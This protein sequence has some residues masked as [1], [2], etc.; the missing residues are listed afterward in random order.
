MEDSWVSP[1]SIRYK[2]GS[3]TV[4]HFTLAARN[5]VE[6]ERQF[7]SGTGKG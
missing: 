3:S 7:A 5:P 4:L 6:G 1:F 2:R